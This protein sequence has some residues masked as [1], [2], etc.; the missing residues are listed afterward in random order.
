MHVSECK[1]R[2]LY[3]TRKERPAYLPTHSSTPATPHQSHS[4]SREAYV[5]NHHFPLRFFL[6][7]QAKQSKFDIY[8]SGCFTQSAILDI[9]ATC[10][11]NKAVAAPEGAAYIEV[12]SRWDAHKVSSRDELCLAAWPSNSCD[13]SLCRLR[14]FSVPPKDMPLRCCFFALDGLAKDLGSSGT[15]SE[16]TFVLSRSA[17]L[18]SSSSSSSSSYA[19]AS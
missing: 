16:S 9:P 5:F 15:S 6:Q 1:Q 12:R 17:V 3:L 11:V 8:R 19:N 14:G 10:H 18:D 4:R 7:P 13:S 2:S